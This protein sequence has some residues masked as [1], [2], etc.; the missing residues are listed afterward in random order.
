MAE[1]H[2]ISVILPL[3]LEWDPWYWTDEQIERGGR[4][5]VL[6]AGKKYIG[7]VDRVAQAPEIDPEKV[8]EI[9]GTENDI[10][11]IFPEELSLWKMV[12]VWVQLP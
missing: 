2:Y 12:A 4:V 10:E 8:K 5:E 1:K 7:V 6:F 11:K 3:K 9:I